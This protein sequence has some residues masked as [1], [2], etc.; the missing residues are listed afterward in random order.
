MLQKFREVVAAHRELSVCDN[1][2]APP[3]S[4]YDA[5]RLQAY[6][7]VIDQRSGKV[8]P[9]EFRCAAVNIRDIPGRL[10]DPLTYLIPA[11]PGNRPGSSLQHSGLR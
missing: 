1:P 7:W 6:L 10:G 8:R 2:T 4:F 3:Q 11:F 5:G 9:L